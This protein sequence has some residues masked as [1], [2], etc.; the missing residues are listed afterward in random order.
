ML[1]LQYMNLNWQF[2]AVLGA[3]CAALVSIFGKVGLQNVDSTTATT[4]RSVVMTLFL[5]IIALS[6]G[7]FSIHGFPQGRELLFIILSGVAGALSWLLMFAA[8]KLGPAAGVAALDRTSVVFVLVLSIMFLGMQ[9]TWRAALGA[10]L[11]VVGA[12]LMV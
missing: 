12:I 3:I 4:I 2:L 9:F 10:V 1:K 5:V 8:L 11:I 6:L 7:K